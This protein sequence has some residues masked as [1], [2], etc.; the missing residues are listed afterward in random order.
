MSDKPRG[1]GGSGETSG[2]GGATQGETPRDE[3]SAAD[4]AGDPPGSRLP[5]EDEAEK[6]TSGRPG[7]EG[8]GPGVGGSG[9][10]TR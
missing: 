10:P 2:G 6:G 3:P 9:G 7:A 8:G 4:I 5:L 1:T